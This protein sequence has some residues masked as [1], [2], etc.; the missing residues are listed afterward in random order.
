M[1]SLSLSLST[2]C[3]IRVGVRASDNCA[4]RGSFARLRDQS[5]S[6]MH[7]AHC[8]RAKLNS[9]NLAN[10]PLSPA[11]FDDQNPRFLDDKYTLI[12][13]ETQQA[14]VG[15]NLQVLPRNLYAEDGD[16]GICAPILYS[17]DQL[18]GRQA[19]ERSQFASTQAESSAA[20]DS[21]A[22]TTSEE[23]I[24]NYLHLNPS[25]GEIRLLRHWP[26]KWASL[27][28]TLVVRATQAD[29]KDRYTLTTL[30]ITRPPTSQGAAPATYRTGPSAQG[31][32]R[33]S[34]AAEEP[35][36]AASESTLAALRPSSNGIEFTPDRLVINVFENVSI[37]DKIARVRARYLGRQEA[38]ESRELEP[39]D[40][41]QAPNQGL[42][43]KT[44]RRT[45]V[46]ELQL[47]TKRPINYQ[48]LDDQ[49]DQFGINGVGEIFIKRPLDYEQRQDYKFRVLA[50]YT[51]YSDICQ[52]QVNVLNVNDNKPKV[53]LQPS[54]GR[55]SF[56]QPTSAN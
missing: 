31:N 34:S 40:L 24:E 12:M 13:D 3:T 54:I 38:S 18:G 47:A 46:V 10:S 51:K 53:G 35:G 14:L 6:F 33:P 56:A 29:N 4:K 15:Q 55:N 20:A 42:Q 26:A 37:N 19:S 32:L 28:M 16:R 9:T 23:L 45:R 50:T 44:A 30:T 21:A 36:F 39:V 17:F 43:N 52:V 22:P 27:P 8:K 49:S 11:D 1:D 5:M 25:S 41:V 2:V 7:A 48:I